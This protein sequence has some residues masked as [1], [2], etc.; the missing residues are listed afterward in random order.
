VLTV[1]ALQKMTTFWTRFKQEPDSILNA[2]RL[3]H[4]ARLSFTLGGEPTSVIAMDIP[5]FAV[6]YPSVAADLQ[7]AGLT[8]KQA[9]AYRIA[10]FRVGFARMAG[11]A[12]GGNTTPM[13]LGQNIPFAPIAPTSVLGQN[14][15]FRQAHDAEF[16]ALAQMGIWSTQ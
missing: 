2:A 10:I 7:A 5:A 16:K 3:K 13:E 15:A 8:A 4:Q 1:D 14:L 11:I 6:A 12:P 9:A